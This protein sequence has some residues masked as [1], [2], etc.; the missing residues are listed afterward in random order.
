MFDGEGAKKPAQV[1]ELDPK[2]NR[3]AS[4][5]HIFVPEIRAGQL[6]GYRVNGPFDPKRGHRFDPQKV[7]LD[8]YGKCV[9]VNSY[10]RARAGHAGDNTEVAM[11]SV[12][13]ESRS[14]DWEGDAPLNRSFSQTVIYEMHVGGFTRHPNSGVAAEKRG[15]FAG[16]I[17]KIPHLLNLGI[18]A[19]ELLPIFQFDPQ[20]APAG[21]SNYWG[22]SPI[23]FFAP[24]AGYSSLP[25]ALGCLREFKDMVKAL[26]RAGI[27][28]ILDVVYNHTAEG[29][30]DGPTLCY[31]GLE[32]SAYYLMRAEDKSRYADYAGCGNTLNTSHPIVR[33]MILDSVHYWVSTMHVDGFRFDLA[34]ILSRDQYGRPTADAPVLADLESD[35]ILAGTKLIAEAWDTELYQLGAF[36]GGNWKEWNGK[37]RDQVRSAL[38]GDGGAVRG[39]AARLL[40]SPDL[41]FQPERAAEQSIN[42]VT[43]HDG[44]TLNDLVTYNHKHNECNGEDNRDGTNNNLSWNCGVEGPASDPAVESL[45]NQ[46]IKNFF[47]VTLFSAGTP[48]ILMGDEVRRTQLGNNNAYCQD[49]EHSWFDWTLTGKHPDILRFVQ[50]LIRFRLS[51]A[52][53]R[54]DERLSLADFLQ[55]AAIRWHGVNLDEPDWGDDSRS[56]AITVKSYRGDRLTHFIL[57]AYWEALE[58]RLPT[59]AQ[60]NSWRRV[61]DTA[62]KPP[63]DIADAGNG[64]P[65]EKLTYTVQPRSAVILYSERDHGTGLGSWRKV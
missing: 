64:L 45:R 9:A 49:N 33:R 2:R 42:F 58:F 59:P 16:V 4:Y 63:L 37:F 15:T 47:V 34:A 30:E 35:P 29:S 54:E 62:L 48:M 13:A 1:I 57:N 22:Y 27:E 41:Y 40:G 8:P 60:G 6:Y 52:S 61:V 11:K 28:I 65:I 25:G 55:H 20:D 56:L 5:W 38:K 23:S 10:N 14:Y 50:Q 31:R 51:F 19:V 53:S 43:C 3:T 24:H 26:H 18:T 44:F 36:G 17:E 12:V 7:L 39:L 21:M 46:Q 32:N